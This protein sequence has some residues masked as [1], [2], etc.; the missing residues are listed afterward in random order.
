MLSNASVDFCIPGSALPVE[1]IPSAARGSRIACPVAASPSM[2]K[3]KSNS[4][5]W[6]IRIGPV[7]IEY[8]LAVVIGVSVREPTVF[9]STVFSSVGSARL[10]LSLQAAR[11]AHGSSRMRR[12]SEDM[13]LEG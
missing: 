13:R 4:V 7:A 1:G 3:A 2:S 9:S 8:P 5:L 12:R 10:L 6:S 11:A